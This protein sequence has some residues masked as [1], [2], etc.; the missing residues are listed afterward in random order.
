MT[1]VY[2]PQDFLMRADEVEHVYVNLIYVRRGY[3]SFIGRDQSP[4][5]PPPSPPQP[6]YVNINQRWDNPETVYG[7]FLFSF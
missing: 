7:E 3:W 6:I 1:D 5:P 2:I 4:S